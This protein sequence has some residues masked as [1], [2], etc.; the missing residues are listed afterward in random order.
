LN[1][2]NFITGTIAEAAAF[3][4]LGASVA[5]LYNKLSK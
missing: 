5:L 4:V 2:F 1:F 3:W